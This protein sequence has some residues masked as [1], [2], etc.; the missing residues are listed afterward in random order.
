MTASMGRLRSCAGSSAGNTPVR[1]DQASLRLA[2]KCFD[3]PIACSNQPDGETIRGMRIF[4]HGDSMSLHVFRPNP[5]YLQYLFG[6]PGF[7]GSEAPSGRPE[8][9]SYW[10]RLISGPTMNYFLYFLRLPWIGGSSGQPEG[11]SFWARLI[12]GPTMNHFS[13]FLRLP[14]IWKFQPGN[15]RK[16]GLPDQ[17]VHKNIEG[18]Q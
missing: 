2:P 7:L 15:R 4:H 17:R 10:A 9:E 8:G 14:W 11:E 5:P 12:S 6:F 18:G 1:R 13:Y 16:K 3:G